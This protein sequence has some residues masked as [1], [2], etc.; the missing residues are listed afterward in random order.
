MVNIIQPGSTLQLDGETYEV[1]IELT[2]DKDLDAKGGAELSETEQ[3]VC[4][5]MGVSAEDYQKTKAEMG[6]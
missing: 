4:S 2:D 3:A 5:Q 6:A 1:I